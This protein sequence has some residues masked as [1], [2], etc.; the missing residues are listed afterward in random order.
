MTAALLEHDGLCLRVQFVRTEFAFVEGFDSLGIFANPPTFLEL[1]FDARFVSRFIGDVLNADFASRSLP[2]F[3]LPLP[4][5]GHELVVVDD[6]AIW[7]KL[8]FAAR[9]DIGQFGSHEGVLDHHARG[10]R[11]LRRGG[12]GDGRWRM[13]ELGPKGSGEGEFHFGGVV[14]LL[15]GVC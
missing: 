9:V 3:L 11:F 7:K 14:G 10:R 13:V 5:V 8:Q 4:L 2:P 15:G 12:G 6:V 1:G